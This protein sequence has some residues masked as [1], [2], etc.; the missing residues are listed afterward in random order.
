MAFHGPSAFETTSLPW[1]STHEPSRT[2]PSCS[3][4]CTSACARAYEW[5]DQRNHPT[6]VNPPDSEQSQFVLARR[7]ID[8]LSLYLCIT[9][10]LALDW[11]RSQKV[12]A[13]GEGT[14]LTFEHLNVVFV[15]ESNLLY[16]Q[17]IFLIVESLNLCLDPIRRLVRWALHD[18][19]ENDI[20]RF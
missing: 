16:A 18:A 8:P 11:F 4:S 10:T 6:F 1:R 19:I 17:C 5:R 13:T 2:R 14:R 12:K 9:Y 15:V 7:Q 3:F 20:I